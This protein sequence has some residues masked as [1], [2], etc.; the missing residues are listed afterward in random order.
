MTEPRVINWSGGEHAF[1]LRIGEAEA[2]DDLTPAGIADLRWRCSQGIQR[3]SLAH[4]PVKVREIV[5]AVRLGLI[6]GGMDAQEARKIAVRGM[7]EAEFAELVMIS[8]AI[9]TDFHSGKAH[10]QPE[11]PEAAEAEA[12]TESV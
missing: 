2:L 6:G 12:Q 9:L 7:E 11:K 4:A 3:G 5:E 1:R 8:F 10:D